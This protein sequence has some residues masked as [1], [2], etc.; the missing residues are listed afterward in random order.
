M[1]SP[2]EEQGLARGHRGDE[3]HGFL[4]KQGRLVCDGAQAAE[5]ALIGKRRPKELDFGEREP[6]IPAGW[7]VRRLLAVVLV[8][9]LADQC[10][11]VAAIMQDR[12]DRGGV[13]EELETAVIL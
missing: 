13:V 11:I 5:G 7:H 6:A 8:D 10:R 9:V 4:A 1:R 3:L 12:R 2:I